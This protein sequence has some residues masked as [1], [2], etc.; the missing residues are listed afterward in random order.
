MKYSILLFSC[1]CSLVFTN[2]GHAI[3]HITHTNKLH[4][5]C[6]APVLTSFS[7]L[8]G[9][10]NTLITINGSNFNDSATVLFDGVAAT[11][12]IISDNEITAYVPSGL[13]A[14]ANISIT[15]SGGCTGNAS[16]DFSLITSECETSDVYI[17]ELY[18]A[19]AG[20]SG[21]IEL[22]N[23][24]TTTITF[25]GLYE[26]QRFR[27]IGDA[28]PSATLI[29]PN[30]IG[31]MQTYIVKIGDPI[32][33]GL[34]EDAVLGVGINDND[35]IKLFKSGVLIDVAQ[36]PNERGYTVI[37]N[38]DA[39][40]PND[41]FVIS[42]W[43]IDSDE[44]C[45][46]LG[47][48]TADPIPPSPNITHPSSLSICENGNAIFT[49]SVDSGAYTY[50]WKVLNAAGV[51]VNVVNDATYSGAT[52]DTLTISNAPASFDANQYYCEMTSVT[53]DLVS[54]TVQ[55]LVSDPPVDTLSNQTVCA[56][57]TLPALADGNY[58]TGTN[59]TGT[60]L[61]AGDIISTT[62]TI[63]IFNEIGTPPDTC[64]NESSF[65]VTV[66]GTPPVDTLSNQ[67][68]CT[69]YTLPALSDGNYFTG[70][71]GTGIPL[72]AGDIISTTQTIYIFNEIGTP[73]DTCSNESS[74]TVTVSGTPPVDTLSNQTVCANYTLPAL[75]DGNY[76]T[77]TNGTG[78]PL[79]AG[80]I[81]STTQTIYIFNEIGTPPDTC[82]NE[83]SF[84]VTVSGT[85]PVDTLSNQTVC[86][87]Y[88]LPALSDGNY[89]TG[90]N[91]TGI[92]LNAGDIISTTQTIYI[93]NEIG[94]PP[95]TCS[96]ESSFTVTV[97]GTPPVDTLSNQTVCANYT[98]PALTDGNY[99][100]G[101]NG[102]GT[103]LNAGDIISTTQTIY[104]FNEIGTPPDTCSNESSFTV[105][106]S[107]TPPV[108]TL[109]NQTVCANYTLPALTDGNYFTGTNGTGTP[110]NAG[111]VI[112]T[113]QTIYIFNEIGTPPD[114]C[115]N[116][117]SF[118]VTVSGTPPVD[119]LS[120]QT[121]CAN[122]T[123]PALTDGNYFT[124]TNGTGTPLNAG[125]II[126]TTQ[127]IYIF[128]EIG[129]PPDTCS[130]ESNFTVTV[131]GTPP[132]DTLS[133]QTVCANYT[134]PALADGNYFTGTN[135]TGTPLNAGD[136][137]S[138]TQ[139]IYIFNEIGTPP[140][141]CSN[142]SSFTVTV[143][144]TPPVD[145]LSNQTVCANYTLP[146]L[147]DGNYFTGTNGTGT[148]L[149]AGDIISTTQTIYIFN[150]IGTPPDTCSNESSFDIT[151]YSVIDFTLT[152]SNLEIVNQT[153]TVV[154]T[155]TSIDYEYALDDSTFQTSPIFSNISNG[156]H[157]LYVQD[158]NGCIVKSIT[159]Q[160]DGVEEI[161]IPL[162]F[163]PNGDTIKDHWQITDNQNTIKDIY[164]FNRYGK[165]LKQVSP[166][167]KSWDGTYRGKM[168]DSNDYWYLIT[169]HSGKQLR[170]H[171]TLKR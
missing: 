105:T 160:I 86:T 41:T 96:N 56:N 168:M 158:S 38:P 10:E 137:I 13:A 72:N 161:N 65:T 49:V 104:I 7:P 36:A 138:T 94:T 40:S 152:D 21:I 143:S 57:Y 26:L 31:P 47:M 66:S 98:L 45:S 110:L 29:L 118:T 120:N 14:T 12:T 134:L 71:N 64:S 101:T 148:P 16:S 166:V 76:F 163:T 78:T 139:T 122:Y 62:Q 128:N 11:F 32:A 25:S 129:T 156:S 23:P 20:S 141:T 155:D 24:S 93:F 145:T 58:F 164:I 4:N 107:G 19:F 151:I 34:T 102:T 117:S 119:T 150:E 17:S 116:E 28:A 159:F 59:G 114:T 68:V 131:S 153:L 44:N 106:V 97:S 3:N 15:S 89:F 132:V 111:D 30:S 6:P 61:N 33:C 100:T 51:W 70:T 82:S 77:G 8:S 130:N 75:T 95:D 1:I 99:F 46:N 149:N 73:P 81:I 60:P 84:T 83:S 108:D 22:Y 85:P 140:D 52:T 92:P 63:Y 127:T 48:H 136:I 165:L 2:V 39:V 67:T 43:L 37:R 125:D 109:S 27:N 80:D 144:G 55:L 169:L 90:T 112:S 162:F 87:N 35:E 126:S 88:T 53:C 142:E 154:M 115:S 121:V 113:T 157:T 9:P 50:Q 123:L 74:F 18:D 170:G 147:T 124:G 167:E 5:I 91:G 69:N 135:G 133:N 146:A 103:P 42:D 54:N 171:F 79:N